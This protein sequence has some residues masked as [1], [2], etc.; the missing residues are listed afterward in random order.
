MGY[1]GKCFR[2]GEIEKDERHNSS[3]TSRL[4][5]ETRPQKD[6]YITLFYLFL[7][8]EIGNLFLNMVDKITGIVFNTIF[9][10]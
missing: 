5:K 6:K 1:G 3:Q 2:G 7:L 8:T 9:L 4:G 10:S